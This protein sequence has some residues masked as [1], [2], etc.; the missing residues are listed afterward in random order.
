MNTVYYTLVST[1]TKNPQWIAEGKGFANRKR[2]Q[3]AGQRLLAKHPGCTLGLWA[4]TTHQ[5]K[6]HTLLE[7]YDEGTGVWYNVPSA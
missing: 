4:M 6:G 3:N 7:L 2:C 5:R 1:T